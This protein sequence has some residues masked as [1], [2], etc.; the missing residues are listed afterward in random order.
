VEAGLETVGGFDVTTASNGRTGLELAKSLRPD[1]L[2]VDLLLPI[3]DGFE[4][5]QAVRC[6]PASKRPERVIVMTAQADPL[7]AASLKM[8]GVDVL[9]A[10]PFY[11]QQ[12]IDAVTPR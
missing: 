9:L 11:L 12:L 4:V 7:P 2:M 5:L 1:I 3:L 10:K 8:L 6:L